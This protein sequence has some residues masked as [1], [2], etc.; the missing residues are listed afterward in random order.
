[1]RRQLIGLGRQHNDLGQRYGGMAPI[2]T[3]TIPVKIHAQAILPARHREVHL[4]QQFRIQ[5]RA[6]QR[7][8]CIGHAITFAQG[9]Q[10]VAFTGVQLFCLRER[11]G[12]FQDVRM[13]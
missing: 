5:Q 12:N 3:S 13:K 6:M 7:A 2:F 9:I 8:M 1:M 4:S 10:R 11:V